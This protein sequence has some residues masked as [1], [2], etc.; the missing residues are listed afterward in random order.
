MTGTATT[1]DA[2]EA[3]P[4]APAIRAAAAVEM[5][6]TDVVAETTTMIEEVAPRDVRDLAAPLENLAEALDTIGIKEKAKVYLF[7]TRPSTKAKSSIMA[8]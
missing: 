5:I 7:W 1:G 8:W 2:T 3:A 6:A 4:A